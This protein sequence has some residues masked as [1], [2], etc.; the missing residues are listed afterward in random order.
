MI[1]ICQAIEGKDLARVE[2]GSVNWSENH[3]QAVAD[4]K[5]TKKPLLILFQ[6]VPG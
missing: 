5:K 2:V 6:E 4:A 1:F 3:D